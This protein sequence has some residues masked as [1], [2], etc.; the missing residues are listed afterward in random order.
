MIQLNCI[1]V[2]DEN[3]ALDL[4]EDN[5]KKV[6]FLNLVKRCKNAFDAIET[7][8]H[9]KIDLLFLD[10]QM[11]GITGVQF[12]QS[13]KEPPMV[14]FITAYQQ[15]ALEGFELS[16]ID[17]LLKP[18]A[19]ER[20][21]KAVNK[22]YELHNLHIKSNQIENETKVLP[23]LE[24]DSL[25]V[26]A[27]YSLVKIKIADITYIEGLKDYIKIH[28]ESNNK[29]IVTRM[30]MKAIEEKLPS[31][32]FFRIHKSYI[33]S[34]DKIESIRNLKIKI[35]SAQIPVSEHYSEDFFKRIG[36]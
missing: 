25:F 8:Q 16:V 23:P 6:P 10:I 18:V 4:L 9:E 30:T 2:D 28:L 35:G 3:L 33:I 13:F 36:Q 12:L 15:Y 26:N 24:S 20:F 22:A 19:F 14:I 32:A 27:D 21:L 17:Y 11:P 29:P 34:L 31:Q 7:L 5:I 1:A